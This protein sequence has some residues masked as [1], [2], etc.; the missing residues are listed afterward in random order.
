MQTVRTNGITTHYERRGEGRPVVF[1][2][3]SIVDRSMWAAQLDA[4]ADDY[5]VVSYDLRGHGHTG[6]S[7]VDRYTIELFADDL[8]ALVDALGL[9]RPVLCGLSMGGLIAQLYAAR[10]PDR[11]SGL[12]LADTFTPPI[13]SR[14]E[15]LLR[16]VVLPF[17]TYPV[18]LV[19]YE[20]VE[21]VNVWV[22]ERLVAG[23]GGDY[24]TIEALRE[25]A[26]VMSTSEFTKVMRAMARFHEESV[27]RSQLTMPV[28]VLY[29]ENELPFV[30]RH[31]AAL[32]AA[33]PDVE[34]EEVP[35]GGHASN[36]DNP[37]FFTDALREFLAR[38]Y[39]ATAE[40]TS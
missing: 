13:L 9:D 35:G 15:W 31:A 38:V 34:V 12:V 18:R 23:A 27:D 4:L 20:R 3:G 6:G 11:V 25:D 22:T 7:A 39:P 26:P 30:K 10:H 1:I 16:R 2:H 29:G 28:L 24:E 21:K 37:A 14:G 32:A 17:F 5:T 40:P 33:L 19:G 36:L 8:A